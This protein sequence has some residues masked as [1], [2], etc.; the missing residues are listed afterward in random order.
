MDISVI[1]MWIECDVNTV[2]KIGVS[3]LKQSSKQVTQ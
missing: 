3:I 2:V 1:E